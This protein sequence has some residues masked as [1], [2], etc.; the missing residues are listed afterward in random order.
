MRSGVIDEIHGSFT[1]EHHTTAVSI[2]I[3][4]QEILWLLTSGFSSN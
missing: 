4:D 1:I 2:T 3:T